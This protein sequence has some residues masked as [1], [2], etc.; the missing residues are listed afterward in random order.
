MKKA[1]SLIVLI[2]MLS[3]CSVEDSKC[4]KFT[5]LTQIIKSTTII[6]EYTTFDYRCDITEKQAIEIA[7]GMEVDTYVRIENTDLHIKKM[8]SVKE[9][10]AFNSL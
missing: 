6:R 10:A 9:D 8:V 3:G 7:D 5:I 2:L 4:W 1:A